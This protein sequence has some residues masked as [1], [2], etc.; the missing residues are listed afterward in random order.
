MTVFIADDSILIRTIVKD[1]LSPYKDIQIAGEASNGSDAVELVLRLKPDIVIMDVDMPIM[2]GLEATKILSSKISIPILVFTH[3]T[4]PELPF[5]AIESG[6]ADFLPKPDFL[7][8]NK[9]DYIESFVEKLRILVNSTSEAKTKAFIGDPRKLITNPDIMPASSI[10]FIVMGASTGGPK[11]IHSIL[12]SLTPPFPLPIT[13]VQHIET[14]FDKGFADWL[15]AET[16]H[17]CVLVSHSGC[18]AEAGT[19]YIAPT[20]FHLLIQDSRLVLDDGP[21]ILNQKPAVDALF[22]S[23][24]SAFGARAAA[25]LLTGMGT[26]GA[27][28]CREVKRLGGVCI[29]QDAKTSLIFGMPRAAI[30]SGGATTVLLLQAIGPAL[31]SLAGKI[32]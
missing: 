11:A 22:R 24:A 28:G 12:S 16:G 14:G 26:D 10:R 2:N 7:A 6:A 1:I 8:I 27:D 21:R 3:N 4:D 23:A 5:R 19:V 29:V 25:V 32:V 9:P 31:E 17:R 20:D 30:E 15:Q 13:I 18:A